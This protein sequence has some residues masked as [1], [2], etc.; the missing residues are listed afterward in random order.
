M[1]IFGEEVAGEGPAPTGFNWGAFLFSG[2]F[3]LGYGRVVPFV[4]LLL[5]GFLLPRLG[6]PGVFIATVLNLGISI[7]CGVNGNEIAWETGR[8]ATHQE[9]QRSMHRWN[10]AAL[11]VVGILLALLIISLI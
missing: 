6:G 7:Y 11:V 4:M 1:S 3:L 10:I 5:S 9:L 8:F 2:V